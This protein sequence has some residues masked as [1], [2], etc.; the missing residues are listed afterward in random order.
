VPGP[1]LPAHAWL[2]ERVRTLVAEAER[3]GYQ[4]TEL[5]R[6]IEELP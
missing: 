2:L 6:V 4:R 3:A 1:S 5:V